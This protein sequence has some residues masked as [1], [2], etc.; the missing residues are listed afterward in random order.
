MSGKE[1][2]FLRGKALY[3]YSTVVTTRELQR[4]PRECSGFLEDDSNSFGE[5][6]STW[7]CLWEG[8]FLHYDGKDDDVDVRSP[9]VELAG[10]IL[11]SQF[12]DDGEMWAGN[13]KV[14]LQVHEERYF[15]KGFSDAQS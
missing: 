15:L 12:G 7:E 13:A 10:P 3:L 5:I 9:S 6:S 8:A 4:K 14:M 11:D 1:M 2:I